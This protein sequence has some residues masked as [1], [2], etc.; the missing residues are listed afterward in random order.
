MIDNEGDNILNP[1]LERILRYL[2]KKK[3]KPTRADELMKSGNGRLG[4]M[5]KN[6]TIPKDNFVEKFLSTFTD[7]SKDYIEKGEGDMLV[8]DDDLI[9]NS[10]VGVPM[11]NVPGSAGGVE[12]YNDLDSTKVVGYLNYPGATKDSIALP[13]HGTSMH[14]FLEDGSWAV[15]RP[16]NDTLSI[17]W[18]QV[19]RIEWSDYRM[20]KRLLASDNEDEVI[21]WSDNQFEIINNRPI[22]APITINKSEIRKLYLLT[23]KYKKEN[24]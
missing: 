10:G 8:G 19:Y 2:D 21:L 20:Y 6:N 3:I 7:A 11:Y 17:V 9:N 15:L 13:V 5:A 22:H 12:L 4:K 14:P 24:N 1:V 16:I 23:D 18:G